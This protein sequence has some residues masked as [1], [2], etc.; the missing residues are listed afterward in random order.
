LRRADGLSM[1][2][3]FYT[4]T[5]FPHFSIDGNPHDLN[6]RDDKIKE[7]INKDNPFRKI[8]SR[9]FKKHIVVKMYTTNCAHIYRD[10]EYKYVIK[11]FHPTPVNSTLCDVESRSYTELEG[12]P[13]TPVMFYRGSSP[14][15]C[16]IMKYL[17]E[18]GLDFANTHPP[19][20]V[21]F[22]SLLKTSSK[23]LDLIHNRGYFH[24]DIKLENMTFDGQEWHLID[25]GYSSLPK[26]RVFSGTYPYVLPIYGGAEARQRFETLELERKA[27]DWF[28]LGLSL[29]SLAGVYHDE[30]C[31]QCKYKSIPCNG[32]EHE[33]KRAVGTRIDIRKITRIHADVGSLY[34]S[35]W[36]KLGVLA[37]PLVELVTEL[38]LTQIHHNKHYII[39]IN[40]QCE[41]FGENPQKVEVFYTKIED[42]WCQ[43]SELSKS[44]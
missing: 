34:G 15:N 27:C 29:M 28:A 10:V 24:G 31:N 37:R 35:N 39:W 32:A 4:W 33:N 14:F 2:K 16:I 40:N 43:L 22:K 13:N 25:F 23:T 8:L 26:D 18:D 38:I 19:S 44:L 21:M 1:L 7:L 11:I 42:V 5:D 17:G 20:Y 6:Q 9:Y 30:V 36:R 41:Y 3:Y 12:I